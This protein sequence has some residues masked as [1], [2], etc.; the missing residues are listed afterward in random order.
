MFTKEQLI[1]QA[2]ENVKHYA[3]MVECL[4]KE[5]E[6]CKGVLEMI[7]LDLEL[8]RIALAKLEAEPVNNG[9]IKC[10]DRMPDDGQEVIVMDVNR[11][12]VQSGIV[13]A[14]GRFVDFNEEYYEV[15]NPSHWMPLPGPPEE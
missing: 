15:H 11:N 1:T 2:R 6:N 8:A 7:E 10:S 13:Y 5:G 4:N 3:S 12:R 9:W 14:Y